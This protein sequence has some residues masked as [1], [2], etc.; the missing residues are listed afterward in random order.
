MRFYSKKRSPAVLLMFLHICYNA[1]VENVR[2]QLTVEQMCGI[3]DV[4][5]LKDEG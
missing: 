4:S 2:N 5:L 3:I 1:D